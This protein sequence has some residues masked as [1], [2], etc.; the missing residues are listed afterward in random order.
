MQLQMEQRNQEEVKQEKMIK[1]E[2]ENEGNDDKEKLAMYT[3]YERS[4]WFYVLN[5]G[6]TVKLI[7]NK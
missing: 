7:K 5:N 3:S 1:V 2:D 4:S 6:K